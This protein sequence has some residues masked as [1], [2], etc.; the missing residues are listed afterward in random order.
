MAAKTNFYLNY[1]KAVF[2]LHCELRSEFM[3]SSIKNYGSVEVLNMTDTRK[4]R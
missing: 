4:Q 1:K 3:C 2:S